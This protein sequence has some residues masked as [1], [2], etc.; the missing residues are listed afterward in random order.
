VRK[1]ASILFNISSKHFQP[2]TCIH[3]EFYCVQQDASDSQSFCFGSEGLS[4]NF[5]KQVSA[6]QQMN[7][8]TPLHNKQAN[9]YLSSHFV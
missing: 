9:K 3:I 2:S 7:S 5:E 8:S 4:G 1:Q 6:R